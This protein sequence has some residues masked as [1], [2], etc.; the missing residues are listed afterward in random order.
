MR[1][2][3]VGAGIVAGAVLLAIAVLATLSAL[4]LGGR[5]RG[6]V[7]HP[8]AFEGSVD[9]PALRV[10]GPGWVTA[11]GDPVQLRGVM[12]PDPAV[13]D[14]ERRL[15]RELFEEIASTGATVVRVPVHPGWWRED[16][17]YLWRY[18][19]P[20][21]RW[22]GEAGLYV[23]VDWHVIGDVSRGT[24]PHDPDLLAADLDQTVQFWTT[25]AGHFAATPHVIFELV[26]EP[27]GISASS[28]HDVAT[29]LVAVVRSQGAKQPVLVGGVEYARDLSWVRESPVEDPQ[30]AYASHIY[31]G[32]SEAL[33]DAWFGD[34]S[35]A[36]AVVLT[37]WGFTDV[38]SAQGDGYLVGSAD[39]YGTALAGYAAERG[40]G[41]V[42]CWWDDAWRPAMLTS[43]GSRT[44]WGRFAVQ[45]L[46]GDGGSAG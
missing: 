20:A 13:L 40:L 23:I 28:W 17:E 9:L 22:A 5:L 25:V 27:Q 7:A 42:A 30:V 8:Q 26:N 24:A 44:A 34:V 29:E 43:D 12:I 45:L 2:V 46:G 33:W 36:H 37:E 14:S 11:E 10:Q 15:S 3:L 1:R 6:P 31:P 35:A 4:G 39:G 32:H 19:D 38:Y 16:D 21:V 41:W 18:L